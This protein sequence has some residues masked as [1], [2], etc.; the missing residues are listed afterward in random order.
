MYK[1]F[2]RTSGIMKKVIMEKNLKS[3]RIDVIIDAIKNA[4]IGLWNNFGI[5]VRLILIFISPIAFAILITLWILKFGFKLL[6]LLNDEVNFYWSKWAEATSIIILLLDE[7]INK[8]ISPLLVFL[9]KRLFNRDYNLANYDKLSNKW[10]RTISINFLAQINFLIGII[11]ILVTL[12]SFI[13]SLY[14]EIFNIEIKFINILVL[15]LFLLSPLLHRFF[16]YRVEGKQ[17]SWE[18]EIDKNRTI[19]FSSWKP[20]IAI[21]IIVILIFAFYRFNFFFDK[22]YL[23]FNLFWHILLG[24]A[25]LA[26]SLVLMFIGSTILEQLEEPNEWYIKVI[27]FIIGAI[28]DFGGFIIFI[29]IIWTIF[30]KI[31]NFCFG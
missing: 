29:I 15:R 4:I 23:T 6:G 16:R 9:W 5:A 3:S 1:I 24:I 18:S 8:K 17:F 25:L 26:I 10:L 31:F 7:F 12:S 22:N 30:V 28:L 27:F 11:L 19:K 13:Y 14:S 20:I 2:S 21:L